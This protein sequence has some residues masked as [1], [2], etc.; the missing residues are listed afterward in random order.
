[1]IYGVRV[2]PSC[3]NIRVRACAIVFFTMIGITNPF[4]TYQYL[5]EYLEDHDLLLLNAYRH[6]LI[7]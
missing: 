3:T 5:G 6:Q 2:L 7:I 4:I 1:M